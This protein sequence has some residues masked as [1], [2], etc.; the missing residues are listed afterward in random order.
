MWSTVNF[1]NRP[2]YKG[3]PSLEILV[4]V[5][6]LYVLIQPFE[7]LY[8]IFLVHQKTL[9][10]MTETIRGHSLTRKAEYLRKQYKNKKN[11]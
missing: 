3:F 9:Q 7:L 4:V 1:R 6:K 11:K 8:F 5:A 10:A 2:E